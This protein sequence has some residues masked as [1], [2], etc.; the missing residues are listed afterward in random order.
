[1]IRMQSPDRLQADLDA[2]EA[3]L[4]SLPACDPLGRLSL[5]AYRGELVS[6]LDEARDHTEHSARVE[7]AFGGEPVVGNGGIH[8]AFL[9]DVVGSLQELL[10]RSCDPS[11]RAHLFVT[12]LSTYPPGVT[13]EEL[14][15]V[16]GRL[17]PSP[18]RRAITS[19]IERLDRLAHGTDDDFA[20]LLDS[21]EPRALKAARDLVGRVCRNEG[22][23]RLA[24]GDRMVHL[25]DAGLERAW[26]RLEATH[27]DEAPF[28]LTGQLLGIIPLGR[29]FEFR[30]DDGRP[31]ITGRVDPDVSARYLE[32]LELTG[33]IPHR[34]SALVERVT[35]ERPGQAPVERYTLLDLQPVSN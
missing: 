10:A 7:A 35:V 18:L 8:A 12:G 26:R 28:R 16:G 31:T 22:T 19:V 9:A 21:L 1:M 27:V 25:C 5:D 15:A 11:G 14:D 23:L 29:R 20:E 30:P 33:V 2:V 3:I 6:A 17:F 24:Q 32:Q 13:L 4:A 34:W